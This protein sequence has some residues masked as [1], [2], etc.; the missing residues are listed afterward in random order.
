MRS[1]FLSKL[2]LMNAELTENKATNKKQIFY[3]QE[4]L[5]NEKYVK[6]LF[7]KQ[8]SDLKLLLEK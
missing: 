1:A 7:L 8:V 5:K 6:D 3:L 2:D 4:D